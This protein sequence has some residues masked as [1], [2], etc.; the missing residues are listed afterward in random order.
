MPLRRALRFRSPAILAI[1]LAFPASGALAASMDVQLTFGTLPSA[2]GWTYAAIGSHTGTPESNVFSVGGGV[3]SVNSIGQSNG[4]AGGSILY[5]RS[6]GITSTENKELLVRARCTAVEPSGTAPQGQAGFCFGFTTAAQRQYA[7]ALSD[8]RCM[9]LIPS[10]FFVFPTVFDNTQFHDY[11]FVWSP[12]NNGTFSLFRDGVL[13]GTSNTGVPVVDNR[14]FF[15]D[16]TG[17]ANGAGQVSSLRFLQAAA[18]PT[19]TSSWGRLKQ[20]Y[21]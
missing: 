9:V 19:Q 13:V 5:N 3:L 21:H 11:R 15:G 10:G 8:T 12:P 1:A 4:V 2:Q 18:V 17:G 20:L 7:F 14:L 6:G 16:G